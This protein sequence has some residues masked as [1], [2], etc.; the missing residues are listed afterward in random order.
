MSDRAE[1]APQPHGGGSAFRGVDGQVLALELGQRRPLTGARQR[2]LA[3]PLAVVSLVV[4]G[5]LFLCAALAP[6]LAPA[7]PGAQDLADTL[8]SPSLHHPL[9][10]DELGRDQLSRV[11]YGARVAVAVALTS[12]ALATVI[13]VLLG[14]LAGYLGRSWDTV[15]MRVAD[16][17]FAF[18]FLV[19][20][21]VIVSLTGRGVGAVIVAIAVFG[22][23]TVA[24]LLRGTM[25]VVRESGFVEASRAT[26]ASGWWIVTRHLLPNCAGP[27]LVVATF[28]IPTAITIEAQLSFLGAGM[29]PGVPD[30]GN[31]VAAG[32]KFFGYKNYL[33]LFPSA[34][35]VVTTM[36]FAFLG[37]GIRDALDP[38]SS[39]G[40]RRP[41]RAVGGRG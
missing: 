27:V 21:L 12:V 37:D 19:G 10:T 33:W 16:V 22:W 31:M 13:G 36:A 6:V 25:L 15:I 39:P 3:N 8:A 9:G 23:A 29:P 35:I 34:A 28:A 40:R 41:A 4:V 1:P 2:F 30:W 18:P 32:H 20:A 11:I 7:D 14:A 24:R 38:R 17:F 26:G 5:L